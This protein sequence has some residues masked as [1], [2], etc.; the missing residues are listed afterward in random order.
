MN[1]KKDFE[2]KGNR[3][4]RDAQKMLLTNVPVNTLEGIIWLIA[5]EEISKDVLQ[6]AKKEFDISE[7]LL[8]DIRKSI[9]VDEK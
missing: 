6:D 7:K 3:I 2:R 9:K 5:I 1:T 4:L 8:E